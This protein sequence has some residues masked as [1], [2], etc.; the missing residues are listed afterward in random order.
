MDIED[1]VAA[2]IRPMIRP[3]PALRAFAGR[4]AVLAELRRA[5]GRVREGFRLDESQR[6][7]VIGLLSA[8]CRLH[9][10]TAGPGCGKTSIMEVFAQ[11]A[12]GTVAF[13]A[14]TG[15][16][17]RVLHARVHRHGF[18]AT[19]IH[20]LLEPSP[21]GFQRN[22]D[23]PIDADIVVVD[24]SS[25]VDLQL[26]LSLLLALRPTAHLVLVGDRDQLP[27][28]GPGNVLA[29]V[30]ELPADHHTLTVTHRNAGAILALVQAVRQGQFVSP[31]AEL[32]GDVLHF[33]VVNTD[34][35]TFDLVETTYLD[36][37]RRV[38]LQQT[39]LLVARRKGRPDT[40]GWNTTYLNARLQAIV[41]PH[42]PA[43][44][45]TPFRIGDR[46][47]IHRNMVVPQPDD[48][49]I[50]V[51]NGDTGQIAAVDRDQEHEERVK[52][53][54][55]A[56]DD[57]RRV[58]MSAELLD[59]VSLAYALTVH[60]AQGSEYRVAIVVITN[61]SPSFMH[62]K[63]LYTAVSR[64]RESLVLFGENATLAAIAR[65]RGGVRYSALVP[66]SLKS[67]Q[68]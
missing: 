17:A 66:K 51:V 22:Q 64:A 27:S 42:G 13:C 11:L 6:N 38:G 43:I 55:L 33:P 44:P 14:P 24:E 40:P 34:A 36:A 20:Q 18:S 21:F 9:T 60:A 30:L 52:T 5:E 16:A 35:G 19:T 1:R 15:K 26:F 3:A 25:M 47:I 10:L 62:R 29:N 28:V 67:S 7:A 54:T 32:T 8:Q 57:G 56:L 65:R 53:F 68:G 49:T 23:N 4:E 61:G 58:V 41:N 37:V 46:V 12:L 59:V 31:G 50:P 48:S 63:V 2:L 45:G 39:G